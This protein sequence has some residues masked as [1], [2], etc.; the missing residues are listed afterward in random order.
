MSEN[1]NTTY[2]KLQDTPK[3]APRGKFITLSGYVMKEGKSKINNLSS[4]FVI[5]KIMA[6]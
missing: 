3:A 5:G 1:K 4:H 6:L 2:E